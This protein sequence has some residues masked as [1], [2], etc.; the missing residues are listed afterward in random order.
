M[1]WVG[2]F[3]V[4]RPLTPKGVEHAYETGLPESD[5]DVIRPL[6]PKGVE[7]GDIEAHFSTTG[8]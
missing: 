2:S 6:T 3:L 4:I 1:I 5:V 8:M 7:H